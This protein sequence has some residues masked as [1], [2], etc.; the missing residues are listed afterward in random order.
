MLSLLREHFTD[1]VT[2]GLDLERSKKLNF[3]W[4]M[5]SSNLN[6]TMGLKIMSSSPKV[7]AGIIH[8]SIKGQTQAHNDINKNL[9]L[10]NF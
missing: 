2:F 3:P 8:R 5:R 10:Y 1:G 6:F 4:S 7:R 9:W